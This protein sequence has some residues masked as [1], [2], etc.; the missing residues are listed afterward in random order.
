MRS[1]TFNRRF[2][3]N[4]ITRRSSLIRFSQL[5]TKIDSNSMINAWQSIV[6]CV[7]LASVCRYMFNADDDK[8]R[9]RE[10]TSDWFKRWKRLWLCH[11]IQY[12][13]RSS[14]GEPQRSASQHPS[15]MWK[16][17]ELSFFGWKK[18][19]VCCGVCFRTETSEP[20]E[21]NR[22]WK[23]GYVIICRFSCSLRHWDDLNWK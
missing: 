7:P 14:S 18:L 1:S 13:I 10:E 21:I 8:K 22:P 19:C 3:F 16:L 23:K 9:E 20:S 11:R 12:L 17:F 6:S 15:P 5:L 2:A 4:K